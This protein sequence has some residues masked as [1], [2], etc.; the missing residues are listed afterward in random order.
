M[1]KRTTWYLILVIALTGL[2]SLSIGFVKALQVTGGA[3]TTAAGNITKPENTVDKTVAAKT[4]A[5]AK[6]PNSCKIL[7]MGDSIALGTGDEK[8]KGFSTNLLDNLRPQTTKVLSVDNIAINGLQS[9]GLMEQLKEEKPKALLA[10]SDLVVIS[11][12]GNDL[13]ELRRSQNSTTLIQNGFKTI[14]DAYLK[15][16]Q[17]IFGTIRKYSPESYIVFV[18]LYNPYEKDATSIEDTKYMN[19]WN[20]DTQKLFEADDRAIFI[21]TYDIF[22]YNL[23]RFIAADGLHPNSLGYQEVAKRISKSVENT[24]NL[25]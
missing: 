13:R 1:F 23:S 14:E 12:G 19:T 8:G 18:G 5:V 21:P 9:D 3:G 7:I 6:D 20:Y 15:N 2:I 10:G 4:Y 11:I 17:E 25:K 22:K 24:F 16:L